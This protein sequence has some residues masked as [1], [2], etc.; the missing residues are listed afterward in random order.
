[1]I[2]KQIFLFFIAFI[3]IGCNHD[4]NNPFD[5]GATNHIMLISP[6]DFSGQPINPTSIKLNWNGGNTRTD[7]YVVLRGL[8]ENT[9]SV[10]AVLSVNRKSFI[11]TNCLP[12]TVY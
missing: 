7:G 4:R 8:S 3:I 6:Q 12:Y 2:F 5:P 1:M 11:D 10:Y 9:M